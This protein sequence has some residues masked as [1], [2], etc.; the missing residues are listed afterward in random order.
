M[1]RQRRGGAGG[2]GSVLALAASSLRDSVMHAR[3]N[4]PVPRA[5]RQVEFKK[6]KNHRLFRAVVEPQCP[7]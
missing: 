5:R 6:E 7:D 2:P 1:L 4:S 3:L